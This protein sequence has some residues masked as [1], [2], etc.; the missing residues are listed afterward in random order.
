MR[1]A[2]H[3]VLAVAALA[4]AAPG[5]A[6]AAPDQ[7]SEYVVQSGETLNG[8]ANRAGVSRDKIIKANGLE[9]P[10]VIRIGQKLKIP[11]GR[12]AAAA[13]PA[14]S[15][16]SPEMETEHI[17]QAGETLGGIASRAKVPR[18]LIAEANGLTPPYVVRVG[19]RLHIP[20]TRHHTVKA[21]ETGFGIAY[22]Y[23]VQWK[24]IAVASGISPDAPISPG[25]KLV[26]PTVLEKPA[27]RADAATASGSASAKATV[28]APA[29]TSAPAKADAGA[30]T[31]DSRF[32]WPVK[33]TVRRGFTPREQSGHHD[34]LDI[35]APLGT[36][37]RATAEGRVIFAGSKGNYGNLVILAH[38]D[39][40]HSVYGYLSRITVKVGEQVNKGE[41]I[42]LVGSTGIAKGNELHFEIRRG[43]KPVDPRGELPA[44]P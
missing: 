32:A 2:L 27:A 10:F 30:A 42:G 8:I 29:P 7:E 33:G 21:D 19:Q 38:G 12:A 36:A 23:G 25:Q 18:V 15:P 39:G 37:V 17:V 3:A 31:A 1:R 6:E 5:I 20:R 13:A 44:S 43:N 24:D 40:L 9:P 22:N 34:G 16:I 4:G 35:Q 14:S 26:I 11:R 41:R 28:K